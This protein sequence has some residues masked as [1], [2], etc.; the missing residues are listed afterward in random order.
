M[1]DGPKK[2]W[3]DWACQTKDALKAKL[4]VAKDCCTMYDLQD[5]LLWYSANNSKVLHA[6]RK[7]SPT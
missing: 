1:G 4:D 3:F 5:A 6:E 7:R 2:E